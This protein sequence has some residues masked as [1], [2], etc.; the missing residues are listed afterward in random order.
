MEVNLFN[1]MKN[2]RILLFMIQPKTTFNIT[3]VQVL[4]SATSG[5]I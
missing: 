5:M 4:P 1:M 2:P 3:C